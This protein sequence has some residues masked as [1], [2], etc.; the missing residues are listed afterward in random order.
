MKNI[1]ATIKQ[2]PYL[3]TLSS[4]IDKAEM[5]VFLEKE[6]EV[7]FF[8]PFDG[9]FDIIPYFNIENPP[10]ESN[11]WGE[12]EEILKGKDN[13]YNFLAY[14][15][16]PKKLT[17]NDL[18]IYESVT[19]LNNEDIPITINDGSLLISNATIIIPDLLCSNGVIHII[20]AVLFEGF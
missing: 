9:A 3:K 11:P 20:N 7:T 16:V 15:L 12:T 5:N 19:P 6:P 17:Q 8:A 4:I 18:F 1:Q 10:F 14:H 13:A 2:I